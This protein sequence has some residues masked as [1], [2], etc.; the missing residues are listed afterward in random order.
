M[1][2]H[3]LITGAS[4]GFGK[5]LA[6]EYA[7]KKVNLVLVSLPNS[8]LPALSNFLKLNFKIDVLYFEMDLSSKENCMNLYRAVK[9]KNIS[10]KYL[11]NNAGMLSKGLFENMNEDYFLAQINV[12]VTTPTLLTK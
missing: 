12:N 10:I 3:T 8:G 6:I 7:K 4:Q 1:K 9:S 11:I 5:A 2:T